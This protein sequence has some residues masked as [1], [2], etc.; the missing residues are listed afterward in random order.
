MPSI[1]DLDVQFDAAQRKRGA[2]YFEEGRVDVVSFSPVRVAALVR[3]MEVYPV[4]LKLEQPGWTMTCACPAF[5]RDFACKHAWAV[6]LATREAFG[7]AVESVPV[8]AD[9]AERVQLRDLE[10]QLQALESDAEDAHAEIELES[11]IEVRYVLYA[12]A[13]GPEEW[14]VLGFQMGKRASNRRTKF[15]DKVPSPHDQESLAVEDQRILAMLP[16]SGWS[17]RTVESGPGSREIPK[18]LEA[19][20][21]ELAART[22]RLFLGE[23]RNVGTQPVLFDPG[24]PWGLALSLKRDGNQVV[25][26]GHLVRGEER[27][28]LARCQRVLAGGV[29]VAGNRLALADWRGAWAWVPTLRRAGEIR[30]PSDQVHRLLSALRT[31][32]G[33]PSVD[34][35]EFVEDL[36]RIASG[37]V[38]VEAAWNPNATLPAR[39]LYQYGGHRCRTEDSSRSSW[40]QRGDRLLHLERDQ[41]HEAA[42]EAE[43]RAAGG[44]DGPVGAA[45]GSFAI[46]IEVLPALVRELTAN[47]WIVEADGARL[48]VA[49]KAR[50]GVASGIDWFDLDASVDFDGVSP[51]LPEL[52]RAARDR[53]SLV[54]L[55]DGTVGLLPEDWLNRWR[56]ASSLGQAHGGKLRIAASQAW[57]LDAWITE[58]EGAI[59]VDAAFTRI[60]ENLR[61]CAEPHERAEPAGFQGELRPYQREGLG[62]MHFL[63]EASVGGILADDMGLGKTV[64]VLALLLERRAKAR[65]PAL[66][67]APLT[68]LF[69]W[70]REA[71]RFTPGLTCVL[72]HGSQRAKKAARIEDADIV[73]TSYGTLRMDVGLLK[74]IQFDCTVLDEAQTIKNDKSQSAKAARLLKGDLRLALSGTPVENHLGELVSILRYTNPELVEG[75]KALRDVLS[76]P[77]GDTAT[78]RLVARAVRP[79]LL[80]RTK[81][82][83]ARDLPPKT[84]QIVTVELEGAERRAYDELRTHIAADILQMEEQLGLEKMGL[85]VLEALLRLRQAACHP[86]LIDPTR[87]GESSA[88]LETLLDRL[89]E[90]IE[91]GHKALVFSQFT[92]FLAIVRARLDARGIRYEYLDGQ[93]KKREERVKAFQENSGPPLFLVSLKAGGAGLN[94]TAADYVFLLDPWWNPAVEAQAIDRTHRIGQT[95]PVTAYRLI[96]RGTIED[97]VCELQERKREL[98]NALF[99]E[100]GTSLRDLSR[101]D[102]AWLLA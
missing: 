90:V 48:R 54:R 71:Q 1:H 67:V 13:R 91:S 8:R 47:G 63:A 44:T 51:D 82:Q 50:A 52:L 56:I 74:E 55:S 33:D 60:R 38:Q 100:A 30:A 24:P 45:P 39:L 42:L 78:A 31:V 53:S 58:S 66:V 5:G 95:R 70:E 94:L 16:A 41:A 3:G 89:D 17:W 93:T 64:Q 29:V 87:A 61:R 32:P 20:V 86:G 6:L 92:S 14:S 57:L 35:R 97:K 27:L 37:V 11:S 28:D 77:R 96:A 7:D 22:G 25:L 12:F 76:G 59:D 36:P 84:E 72:H 34:A 18:V 85:H 26:A 79:F 46:P 80:R 68:V 75:S 99:E 23:E 62:W 49:G 65:G 15:R 81:E 43:F 98:A 9:A 21:L 88:K 102:L 10:R 73:V 101:A 40:I 19:P 4:H 69:N 2:E 83:V